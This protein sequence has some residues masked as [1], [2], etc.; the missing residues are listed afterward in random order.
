MT[1]IYDVFIGKHEYKK[2]EEQQK[3][4]EQSTFT[5]TKYPMCSGVY[6]STDQ[7]KIGDVIR[8]EK[9]RL[10][11]RVAGTHRY[12][13]CNL[14]SVSTPTSCPK[15]LYFDSNEFYDDQST[16][17]RFKKNNRMFTLNYSKFRI[18]R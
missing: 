12:I 14:L 17:K 15:F 2:F 5:D 13:K 9:T 7:L 4:E 10:F 16:N 3:K 18:L 1:D 11:Y 6:K 8:H